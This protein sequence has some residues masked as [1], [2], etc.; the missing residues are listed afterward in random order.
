VA[1]LDGGLS[2]DQGDGGNTA[3]ATDTT[4]PV[5]TKPRWRRVAARRLAKIS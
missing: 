5:T 2:L 1:L 3:S 4:A